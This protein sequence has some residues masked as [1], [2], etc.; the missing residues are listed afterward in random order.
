M[1][2][3]NV[4]GLTL[5]VLVLLF[6]LL[7]VERRALWL[8]LV[9]L[10]LPSIVVVWRWASVGGHL[11]EAGVALAIAL[12][13][14]AVWWLAF[15]RRMPRPTSDSIKVWGQEKLPKVKPDEA[16]ALKSENAQLREQN[17]QLE[18]ELRQLKGG[19]NG[20]HPPATPPGTN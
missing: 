16:R 9:L 7:R 6:V 19:S 14:T 12:P 20:G 4:F 10:V 8:V 15:G 17:E 3:L 18:A 1:N 11:G 5:L 2:G 13:L